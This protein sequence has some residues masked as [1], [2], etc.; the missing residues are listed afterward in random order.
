M[1]D[2][3]LYKPQKTARPL[4]TTAILPR[5]TL[6]NGLAHTGIEIFLHIQGR[7]SS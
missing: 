2:S 7:Y 6:Y 3:G 4:V 5:T 1:K